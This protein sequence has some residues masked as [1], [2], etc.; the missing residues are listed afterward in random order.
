MPT[1]SV[2]VGSAVGLHARPA[3]IIAEAVVNSGAEVTLS[4]DGGEPVPLIEPAGRGVHLVDIDVHLR[5]PPV[6][7]EA[8]GNPMTDALMKG[9][10]L[11]RA[12]IAAI[13]RPSSSRTIASRRFSRSLRVAQSG[14]GSARDAA[15]VAPKRARSVSTLSQF[16]S[17]I[18]R[19][20]LSLKGTGGVTG[21]PCA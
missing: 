8:A 7:R 6:D 9:I 4:L 13:A 3:A 12:E 2:V 20:V 18:M 10:E 21:R 1:T 5:R 15:R 11:N 16:R 17:S 19:D 14:A